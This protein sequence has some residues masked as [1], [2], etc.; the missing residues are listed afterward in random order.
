MMV[1]HLAGSILGAKCGHGTNAAA[2]ELVKE[3]VDAAEAIFD[4]VE[5]RRTARNGEA[6]VHHAGS[7]VVETKSKPT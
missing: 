1:C 7:P 5:R 3:A 2:P 4:E 6:F